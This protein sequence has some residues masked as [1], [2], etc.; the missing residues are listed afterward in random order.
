[1]H[2]IGAFGLFK[3]SCKCSFVFELCNLYNFLTFGLRSCYTEFY[4]SIFYK[5]S[6]DELLISA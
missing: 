2:C 4:D 3:L 1:M 5:F 6:A